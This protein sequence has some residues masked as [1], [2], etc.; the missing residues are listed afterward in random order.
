VQPL[1]LPTVRAPAGADESS[2]R[3][4]FLTAAQI[5]KLKSLALR[6]PGVRRIVAR[7]HAH[8]ERVVPWLSEAEPHVRGGNVQIA[9]RPPARL[10][11]ERLPA[12]IYP[13]DEAPFGT[14][15]LHRRARFWATRVTELDA[16]VELGSER[17]VQVEPAGDE[18]EVRRIE[19]VGPPPG[20]AYRAEPD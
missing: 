8:V 14:P 20:P 11:D 17:I 5:R 19:L 12:T 1:E 18:V 13:N 2:V 9:M 15:I 16:T 7:H 6:D 4:P 10:I 3:P